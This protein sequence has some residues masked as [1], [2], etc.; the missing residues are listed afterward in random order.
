MKVRLSKLRGP[1]ASPKTSSKPWTG[2]RADTGND[3][4]GREQGARPKRRAL[5]GFRPAPPVV[6]NCRP[7]LPR[8]AS[9]VLRPSPSPPA[10]PTTVSS[11][12]DVSLNIPDEWN[13]QHYGIRQNFT[14]D[15][16][17]ASRRDLRRRHLSPITPS[18]HDE[19]RHVPNTPSKY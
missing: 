16:P 13:E 8:R 15:T 19:S 18:T 14:K 1:S 6:G 2:R 3:G 10:V 12:S 17:T 7:H 5:T 9:C 11:L 4:D